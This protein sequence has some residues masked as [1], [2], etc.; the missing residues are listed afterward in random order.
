M[1][2]QPDSTDELANFSGMAPLFPLPNVV[3]YPQLS[4]PLHIF[5]PRYRRMV[6]DALQGERLIA[7]ALLQPGWE[8]DYEGTPDIYEM[9]CV[10]KIVA[11]EQLPT[12]KYN[13]VL[14][15]IHRAVVVEEPVTDL[16][17]RMGKLELYRDFYSRDTRLNR[18]VRH[19]ELL[20]SFRRLFPRNQMDALFSQVLE[21]DIP[22]GV[23]CDILAH[24]LKMPPTAKQSVLEEL[25][26]D[27][28]SDLI[29]AR[30]RDALSAAGLEIAASRFPPEFS[31]N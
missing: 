16:P 13:L 31:L 5:E 30:V 12:G 8:T 14:K 7:M 10:G 21:S 29:L 4:Q 11:A 28:R 15:G 24:A 27:V 23:L 3:L 26:V 9:V 19:K 6:A 1:K 17:Y 18:E 22:L 25:D 2:P 20:L